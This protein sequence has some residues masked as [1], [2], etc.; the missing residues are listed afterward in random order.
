MI[1]L[2]F[3]VLMLIPCEV[4]PPF[5]EEND[6]SLFKIVQIEKEKEKA[7]RD[8]KIQNAIIML[9]IYNDPGVSLFQNLQRELLN[10]GPLAAPHLIAAM[11]S[12]SEERTRINAGH[13]ATLILAKISDPN[14]ESELKRLFQSSHPRIRARAISCMG[15][16]GYKKYLP[17]I[18]ENLISRDENLLAETLIAMGRFKDQDVLKTASEFIQQETPLLVQASLQSLDLAQL[19]CQ[20]AISLAVEAF[21]NS[22]HAMTRRMALD[23]LKKNGDHACVNALIQRCRIKSLPIK[24]K[25]DVL[26]A[27]VAIGLRITSNDRTTIKNYLKE[28]LDDADFEMVK[29][30]AYLLHELEDDSGL[31]ILTQ[32]LNGLIKRHG[33]SS[34][35]FKRG[36][37]FLFFSRHNQ[38]KHDFLE[39]LKRL[40]GDGARPARNIFLA[41]ARCFAAESRFQE[42]EKYIRK[43]GIE[44][45]TQLPVLYSEF[46]K[47]ARDKRFGK[48]FIND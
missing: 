28:L 38:A 26:E 46:S 23:Y 37:I 30:A 12:Q 7:V 19:Q 3:M 13:V 1:K 4:S 10:Y 42:S 45:R 17:E 29:K 40:K 41:L 47:M 8:K 36:E 18:K 16:C 44:D 22:E 31:K 39:G 27:L 48:S 33:N 43:S 6:L 11:E 35:Y 5:Q 25:F 34:Y 21:E 32:S 14:I 24:A 9:G 15:R 2:Y 20:D